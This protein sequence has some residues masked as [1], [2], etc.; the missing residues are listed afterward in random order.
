MIPTG[1]GSLN[2]QAYK[3]NERFRSVAVHGRIA[4]VGES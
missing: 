3:A 4:P 2:F 1:L